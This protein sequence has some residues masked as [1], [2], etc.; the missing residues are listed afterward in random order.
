MCFIDQSICLGCT[1]ITETP[2]PKKPCSLT[3]DVLQHGCNGTKVV[4]KLAYTGPEHCLHCYSNQLLKIQ[5]K[6]EERQEVCLTKAKKYGYTATQADSLRAA[7]E[8]QMKNEIIKL[9]QEWEKML[10]S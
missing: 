3:P 4:V 9:D 6:C 10:R 8:Q 7:V 5:K 1:T 2:T